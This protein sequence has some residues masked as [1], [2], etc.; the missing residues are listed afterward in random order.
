MPVGRVTHVLTVGCMLKMDNRREL[1]RVARLRE[2]EYEF[3]YDRLV[4]GQWVARRQ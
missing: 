1:R 3:H 2:V 4:C